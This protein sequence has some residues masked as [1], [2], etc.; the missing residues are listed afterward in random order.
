VQRCRTH[1]VRNV[2]ERITDKT[3]KA[4]T[5]AVMHAAYKLPEKE[6]MKRLTQQAEWLK[7]DYPDAAVS[8]LEGLEETFTV[9]RLRDSHRP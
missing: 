7:R 1:K 9:N 3:V 5:K 4:Q 2:T 8:L 6:G